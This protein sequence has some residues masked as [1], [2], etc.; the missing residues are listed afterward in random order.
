MLDYL[1]HSSFLV[2]CGNTKLVFDPWLK[3]PAYFKQWYLWPPASK[4]PE[5]IVSGAG[6]PTR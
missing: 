4:Q 2:T 3:G 6:P 5:E 1:A